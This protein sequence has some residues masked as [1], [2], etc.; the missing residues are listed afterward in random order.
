MSCSSVG[1][2]DIGTSGPAGVDLAGTT[3]LHG[4]PST[5]PL[6]NSAPYNVRGKLGCALSE[7]IEADT[8]GGMYE[9]EK[10][11][12]ARLAGINSDAVDEN[13]LVVRE[14]ADTVSD[15]AVGTI[16]AGELRGT[17]WLVEFLVTRV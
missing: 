8:C 10:D 9:V 12:L 7:A 11:I 1:W 5:I 4:M 13:G 16:S 17:M 6:M 15:A 3:V 14:A 2:S